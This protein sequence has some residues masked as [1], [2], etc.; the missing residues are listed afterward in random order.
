VSLA[1]LRRDVA[2]MTREICP[3]PE[4]LTVTEWA[5]RYRK[6]PETSTSPGD[7]DSSV[8]PYARRPMDLTADPETVRIAL[9]WGTQTT[10]STV[11]ENAVAYRIACAPTPMVMVQPKIDSAE[12]MAKERIVPMILA[13]PELRTRVRLG[14]ATD[15][16]LRYKRFSGGFLFIA[17]ARSGPELASRSAP[18]V[19]NDE[20]DEFDDIPGQGNP[21]EIVRRRQGAAEIGLEI[22]TSTPRDA[23]TSRIWP[24]L[25]AGTN[26]RFHV[27]CPHCETMQEL[28]FGGRD[29]PYGLKWPSGQP[30]LAQYLCEHCQVLIDPKHKP[31]ML[32]R[33]EWI[34]TNPD[35]PPG[36]YSFHLSSLYSPFGKSN[37][38]VI[39]DEFV[40]A[41]NKP[42]D[43]QVFVNTRLAELFVDHGGGQQVEGLLQR[44][45]TWED[46]TVPDRVGLLTA[47]MDVQD[48]RIE[49]YVWGW[50]AGLESWP[51]YWALF[52][53]DTGADPTLPNSPWRAADA[54]VAQVR[55]RHQVSGAMVPISAF[56]LDTGYQTSLCY[57]F[58]NQWRRFGCIATK[59]VGGEGLPTLGKPTLQGDM[60]VP[61]F[62]IGV[63]QAKTDWFKS[64]LP[65][66]P[67]PDGL[68]TPG[69]VHLPDHWTTDQLEQLVSEKLVSRLIKGRV[70]REWIKKRADRPNEALDCRIMAR[71]ALEH[72][73]VKVIAELG[74]RA[75]KLRT[76][77]T[78]A[79]ATQAP[80][81]TT[82]TIIGGLT[83]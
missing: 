74:A 80:A 34:P 42:A 79:P 72:L 24:E 68:P 44:T 60:R 66:P 69:Y 71:V 43:L 50:G 17:S 39:A 73:G 4:R 59:G 62:S 29:K 20:I 1:A 61:L 64:D 41:A 76:A 5:D 45:E 23:D 37:W 33:G 77:A 32:A 25:E 3:T 53:G 40:R 15:S 6:L 47:G 81:R 48:N 65:T 52:V 56:G 10:K 18:F 38:G 36:V 46:G 9:C 55:F 67:H 58:A 51:I 19:A 63:Y 14:K 35:A 57:K 12:A 82:R 7:Y 13:T 30:Q 31:W 70:H 11:I 78:D 16:S 83:P 27:P 49:V 21:I 22:N 28:R 26:E 54:W 8:T 2:R 75:E